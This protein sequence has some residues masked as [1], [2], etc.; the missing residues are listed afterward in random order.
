MDSTQHF[1]RRYPSRCTMFNMIQASRVKKGEE[2]DVQR[3]DASV[4]NKSKEKKSEVW[5]NED[6]DNFLIVRLLYPPNEYPWLIAHHGIHEIFKGPLYV[7]VID[8]EGSS[9]V[10][11]IL[12]DFAN[13]D[14]KVEGRMKHCIVRKFILDFGSNVEANAFKVLHDGMILEYEERKKEEGKKNQRGTIKKVKS[15]K[16]ACSNLDDINGL[17][18]NLDNSERCC[19]PKK[20]R[21]ISTNKRKDEVKEKYEDKKRMK[22]SLEDMTLGDGYNCL[23]NDMPNT[24]DPFDFEG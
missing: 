4:L 13:R 20:R 15:S 3:G 1:V 5:I 2:M 11:L 7:P 9:S 10:A 24:Q 21:R 14:K 23:D 6:D 12:R 18:S 17:L 8:T 22:Q 19:K 16:S